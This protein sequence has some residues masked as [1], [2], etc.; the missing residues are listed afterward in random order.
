M[1]I[2]KTSV[3]TGVQ[4]AILTA[5]R[6]LVIPRVELGMKSANAPSGQP[7]DGDVLKPDQRDF[8]SN[9]GGLWTTVSSKTN[10]YT[11][12]RRL[13]ETHLNITEEKDDLLVNEK[14]IDGQTYAHHMVTGQNAP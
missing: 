5:I 6:S 1:D 7:V 2:V 3:E 9:I 13:E 14:N 10:S 12:L 8:L 11:D 4:D